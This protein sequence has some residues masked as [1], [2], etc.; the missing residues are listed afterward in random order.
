MYTAPYTT[1]VVTL[2]SFI[3]IIVIL[4]DLAKVS[5]ALF[6]DFEK[7]KARKAMIKPMVKHKS[8]ILSWGGTLLIG[9]LAFTHYFLSETET[10]LKA[11][12]VMFGVALGVGVL[13]LIA[14]L[15]HAYLQPKIE[16][17]KGLVIYFIVLSLL[18][19][20]VLYATYVFSIVQHPELMEKWQE[21]QS[22][23]IQN[24]LFVGVHKTAYFS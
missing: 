15:I 23:N 11:G 17:K 13:F 1:G 21:L 14:G 7:Y 4:L 10:N 18:C 2:L 6:S 19:G 3:F 5:A 22:I 20:V 16:S 9:A 12:G 24:P 8:K